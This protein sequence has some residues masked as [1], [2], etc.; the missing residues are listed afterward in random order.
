[1]HF[2]GVFYLLVR[3][4]CMGR[5]RVFI[6]IPCFVTLC[7]M[8]VF[9]VKRRGHIHA[10]YYYT[11]HIGFTQLFKVTICQRSHQ[12]GSLEMWDLK[13][14]WLLWST[15]NGN[16]DIPDVKQ[17]KQQLTYGVCVYFFL[18]YMFFDTP[19]IYID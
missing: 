10:H 16:V 19:V 13:L 5:E 4:F 2:I 7:Y 17:N 11:G 18:I 1:M 12:P 15:N 14:V 3:Q 8:C 9:H 6:S